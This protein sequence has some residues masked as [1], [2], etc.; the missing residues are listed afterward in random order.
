MSWKGLQLQREHFS[1]P[2]RLQMWQGEGEALSAHRAQQRHLGSSPITMSHR[3]APGNEAGMVEEERRAHPPSRTC[4]TELTIALRAQTPNQIAAHLHCV[5]LA[6]FQSTKENNQLL[7]NLR[8]YCTVPERVPIKSD[9]HTVLWKL[10]LK[11]CLLI[12]TKKHLGINSKLYCRNIKCARYHHRQRQ[13]DE[14]LKITKSTSTTL[15]RCV[16][17]TIWNLLFIM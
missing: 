14:F 10:L 17:V 12:I 8:S 6:S 11:S 2:W 13:L 3:A 4:S 7:T 9:F 5:G 15:A 16:I 1:L